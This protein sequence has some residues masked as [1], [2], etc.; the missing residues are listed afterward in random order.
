M[1][2]DP[3]GHLDHAIDRC[4]EGAGEL[5]IDHLRV[6]A[7][8]AEDRI[9]GHFLVDL[10]HIAQFDDG[11]V[12]R[13]RVGRDRGGQ[14]TLIDMEVL[15]R[16]PHRD[17]DGMPPRPAMRIADRH[18]AHELGDRVVHI[19]L[20]DLVIFEI[21]L[22]DADALALGAHA[23]TVI[24]VD[25]ERHALED[26]AQLGGDRSARLAVR[27]IDFTKQRRQDR[28]PRRHLDHLH[29][30][31]GRHR[32]RSQPLAHVE[33]DQVTG[34]IALALRRQ[35]ELQVA[36]LGILADIVVAHETVEVERRRRPRMGLDRQQL[37]QI[38]QPIGRL[39]QDPVRLLQ[40]GPFRQVDHHLDFR[41]VVERQQLHRDVL[42]VDQHRRGN[43]RGTDQQQE[44]PGARPGRDNR[45]RGEP[46]D[47]SKEAAASPVVSLAALMFGRTEFH[48]Q[49]RRQNDRDEERKQHRRRRIGRDRAHIGAHQ[50]RHEQHR[51]QRGNHRHRGD[52]G[53]VA[54]FRHGLDRR[55]GA[56]SAIMHCPV[57]G[58]VLDDDDGI[59]DE[60]TD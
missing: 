3:V 47:A 57:A 5:G 45:P 52:D 20:A 7:I 41:L 43:G 17:R 15:L 4:L 29:R 22:V 13:K 1:L 28:R 10:H 51:Q 39:G 54:D 53:R 25:D 59:V 44:D 6:A 56:G 23:E 37:R 31:A 9:G 50:A 18:A 16:Q 34:P 2:V 24:H 8:V 32:E 60:D 46:V 49:P 14:Q 26:L 55:L 11:A 21:V 36:K 58:D 19:L 30:R 12:A 33:R 27:A 40:R 48:H 38:G 35:V 42:G